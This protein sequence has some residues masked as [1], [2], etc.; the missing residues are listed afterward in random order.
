MK[1][2][3]EKIS[4]KKKCLLLN[5]QQLYLHAWCRQNSYFQILESLSALISIV[6]E[7]HLE[8]LI[9]HKQELRR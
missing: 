2:A 3:L 7:L 9:I 6:S 1:H 8:L 5:E 4:F